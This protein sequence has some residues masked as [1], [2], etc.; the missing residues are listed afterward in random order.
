M[1]EDASQ[2]NERFAGATFC[3]RRGTAGLGP[4]LHNAHYGERLRWKGLAL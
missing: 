4:S 3:N 1:G 2:R